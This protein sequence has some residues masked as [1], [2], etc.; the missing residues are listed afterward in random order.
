MPGFQHIEHAEFRSK[1]DRAWVSWF[2]RARVASVADVRGDGAR[3]LRALQV[4]GE[5]PLQ[6]EADQNHARHLLEGLDF[7]VAQ[8]RSYEDRGAGARRA[9]PAR[10]GASPRAR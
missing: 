3:D 9:P 2:R 10:R 1:F 8:D 7:L 5:N 6:S 4:I